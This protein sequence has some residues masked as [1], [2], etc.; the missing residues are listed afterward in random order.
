MNEAL[1]SL[2]QFLVELYE[3]G[4]HFVKS[5][6]YE[7]EEDRWNELLGLSHWWVQPIFLVLRRVISSISSLN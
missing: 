6:P 7:Y 2:N 3:V 4:S 5:L 1:P